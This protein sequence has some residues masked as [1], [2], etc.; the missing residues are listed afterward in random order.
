[1]SKKKEQST[2]S[3]GVVPNK[4]FGTVKVDKKK[5]KAKEVIELLDRFL[6]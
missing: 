3:L 6:K 2:N 1:M 4:V 5:T